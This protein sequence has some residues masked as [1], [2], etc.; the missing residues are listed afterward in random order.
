MLD[1]LNGFVVELRNAGLPVSLT[2]NLDAMEAVQ[3]IPIED[4]DAFKYALGATLVKNH[5]H[6]RSFETVFEV[7]FSLRGP[8][9]KIA[10]GDGDT[11]LDE[12]WRAMQ[13]MQQQGE[14]KGQGGMLHGGGQH[15]KGQGN[16]RQCG[17]RH[18]KG[19]HDDD[20]EAL[21]RLDMIEARMAKIEAMLEILV[22]R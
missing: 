7:Y 4:R 17:G 5:A 9:Y 22:R 11:D 15:G 1:L 2:E 20:R 6:W 16:M 21:Q 19:G 14:G 8:E 10:E 13:E 3:H 18:R 12:L